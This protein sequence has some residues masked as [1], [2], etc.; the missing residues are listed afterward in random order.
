[1][2]VR[3]PNCQTVYQVAPVVPVILGRTV[4][5]GACNTEFELHGHVIRRS[6]LRDGASA[7]LE[8]AGDARKVKP[9]PYP[10]PDSARPTPDSELTPSEWRATPA[11]EVPSLAVDTRWSLG[12]GLRPAINRPAQAEAGSAQADQHAPAQADQHAP[13]QADQHLKELE[14]GVEAAAGAATKSPPEPELADADLRL[15]AGD[16]VGVAAEGEPA[17][18]GSADES[19]Q[20]RRKIPPLAR[21]LLGNPA[22]SSSVT[23]LPDAPKPVVPA[24]S[25]RREDAWTTATTPPAAKS[26]PPV[27]PASPAP[28]APR[29]TTTARST[30]LGGVVVTP[31]D[32]LVGQRPLAPL[33]QRPPD[34]LI[35]PTARGD[36][37]IPELGVSEQVKRFSL[38]SSARPGDGRRSDVAPRLEPSL[39]LPEPW[40][41]TGSDNASSAVRS[42]RPVPGRAQV[43]PVAGTGKAGWSRPRPWAAISNGRTWWLALGALVL[44]LTLLM[45]LIY[46]QRFNLADSDRGRPYAEAVCA[47]VGCVLPLPHAQGRMRVRS[48]MLTQHPDEP[49]GLLMS[50]L[51]VNESR[52]RV[53]YPLLR[54]RILDDTQRVV[55]E[56]VFHPSEYL[57]D[58]LLRERWADGVA[59]DEVVIV[60]LDLAT[61]RADFA[62]FVVDLR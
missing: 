48:S 46:A 56:R 47:V 35:N 58:P 18:D 26:P 54:L 14:S 27:V 7:T 37:H 41:A 39:D 2:L 49:L 55:R 59:P 16:P 21:V 19:A 22:L 44:T 42:G 1:M 31:R 12:G 62:Q 28:A 45:Q 40:P 8:R 51:L 34:S 43:S 23:R 36:R 5:C 33:A 57:S 30:S 9:L 10:D 60:R 61:P 13:A 6:T 50:A 25:S 4:N 29:P 15:Q 32:Q 20:A 52:V 11:G 38:Q 24:W 17:S 3:C 53:A